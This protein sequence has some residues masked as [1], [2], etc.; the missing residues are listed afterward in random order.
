MVVGV[1]LPFPLGW[2]VELSEPSHLRSD[3]LVGSVRVKVAVRD[4]NPSVVGGDHPN[5]GRIALDDDRT[6]RGLGMASNLFFVGLKQRRRFHD[7]I[8]NQD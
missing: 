6:T 2:L 8:I 7:I 1:V 5:D 3:D 4:T